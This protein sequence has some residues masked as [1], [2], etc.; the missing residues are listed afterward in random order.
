M[1][2]LPDNDPVLGDIHSCDALELV[3]VPRTRDLGDGL[4]CFAQHIAG[5][6]HAVL[7]QQFGKGPARALLDSSSTP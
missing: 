2:W 5:V 7:P 4:L 6:V 3:I 1:S